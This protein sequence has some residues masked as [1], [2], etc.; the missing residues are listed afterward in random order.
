M[1][2][3]LNCDQE[4]DSRSDAKWCSDK[5]RKQLSRTVKDDKSDK[6]VRDNEISRTNP[7]NDLKDPV[8]DNEECVVADT[9]KARLWDGYST[10][11]DYEKDPLKRITQIPSGRV[12]SDYWTSW[13]YL[14]LIEELETKELDQLEKE[15][16][17]I[18][19]WR[20]TSKKRPDINNI[21]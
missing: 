18:P 1:G 19:A 16:Y 15:K 8:R 10:Y 4:F 11:S 17:F 3:C 14:N 6:S 2:K 20:Y 9:D 21:R 12:R 13:T 7:V 5:C